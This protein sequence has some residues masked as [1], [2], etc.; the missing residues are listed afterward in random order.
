MNSDN[1][2]RMTWIT[3]ILT[4]IFWLL[5]G[6]FSSFEIKSVQALKNLA[7]ATSITAIF[8]FLYGKFLWRWPIFN[9]LLYKPDL[10]GTWLGEFQS[11]W[12]DENNIGVPPGRFVIVIRQD[13]FLSLSIIA[14]TKEMSSIS[15]FES[16][17]IDDKNGLKSLGYI[18]DQK[19]SAPT[20]YA[21]KQG[22]AELKLTQGL[23]SRSLS[24]DFWTLGKSTGYVKVRHTGKTIYVESF[25]Q[26]LELW[27]KPVNW[28]SVN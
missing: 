17:H 14:L 28:A 6:F 22:A 2:K 12:K 15:N 16:L 7:T 3:V 8:W 19:R 23:K 11:D 10:R 27:P 24:G 5:I 21:S 25:D 9:L 1:V 26:A 20:K 13:Y 4:A 18:F